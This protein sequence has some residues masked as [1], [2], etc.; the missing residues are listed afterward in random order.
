MSDTTDIE[1]KSLEAH[2]ELCAERYRF[3]EE[4]LENM[5]DKINGMN[6]V[7][8]EIHDGV[9]AFAERRNNQIMTF[10]VGLTATLLGIIGFL[11][12]TY[13]LK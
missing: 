6:A 8:R 5:E 1:K 12:T 7:I 2:V 4:K 9:M 10:G 3:L 13:V 11:L